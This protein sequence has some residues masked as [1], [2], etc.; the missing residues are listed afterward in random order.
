MARKQK[1][2]LF[3][4]D[5]DRD[6]MNEIKAMFEN[7]E[8]FDCLVAFARNSVW[9]E[10]KVPLHNALKRGMKARFAIGL[11]FYHTD[12]RLLRKLFKL[13]K[14]YSVQ[15]FI[16]N[17][18]STFHPKIYAFKQTDVCNV[19]IGSANL[20]LGGLAYNHEASVL[21]ND[22]KR[23]M[24]SSVTAYFN[25][26]IEHDAIVPAS[27]ARI[28][29]Y[30]REH[31]IYTAWA[32]LSRQQAKRAIARGGESL[33]LLSAKLKLMKEGGKNSPFEEQ[34]KIRRKN[35]ALVQEQLRSMSVLNSSSK[36]DFLMNFEKLINLFIS[37]GLHRGKT[38]IARQRKIFIQAIGAILDNQKLSPN[39]NFSSLHKYFLKI[40]R[41]GIN[42][43]TEILH[44]LDN[45]RFAIMNKNAISGMKL[46]G[47]D[48][49]PQQP[50]KSNVSGADY[51]LYCDQAKSLYK[52]L[53]L[54]NFT[55]LDALFNYIYWNEDH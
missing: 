42:L 31:E 5:S 50:L 19:I 14:T 10:I 11:N 1:V 26:L 2:E 35:L 13:Q 40:D 29:E 20:T 52:K 34:L 22:P 8:S 18:S 44:S 43:L 36:S 25:D 7:T 38:K 28:D 12:P 6:H 3:L 37:G 54:R 30:A 27:K 17:D 21:I 9:D 4:N 24:M 23:A 33:D 53:G 16:S 32:K 48:K 46:A 45:K 41:A 49:Y 47:Y 55:E 15:L 39:E 51:Q